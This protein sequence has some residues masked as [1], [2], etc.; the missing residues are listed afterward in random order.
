MSAGTR[1][2]LRLLAALSLPPIAGILFLTWAINKFAESM[3]AGHDALEQ[4]VIEE[5]E[6]W[7]VTFDG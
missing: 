7:G 2:G 3:A 4:A 1:T 5:I 6:S